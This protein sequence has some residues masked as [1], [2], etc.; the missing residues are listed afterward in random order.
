MT[1]NIQAARVTLLPPICHAINPT[2][3]GMAAG[4]EDRHERA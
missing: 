2:G 3:N 4:R 1:T